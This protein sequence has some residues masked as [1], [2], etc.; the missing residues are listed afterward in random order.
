MAQ[1]EHPNLLEKVS[2]D[3]TATIQRQRIEEELEQTALLPAQQAA[4]K[5][6]PTVKERPKEEMFDRE[7]VHMPDSEDD[8]S[9]WRNFICLSHACHY[10]KLY[11]IPPGHEREQ[12][13]RMEVT[14]LREYRLLYR[15]KVHKLRTTVNRWSVLRK[16]I[17]NDKLRQ[18]LSQNWGRVNKSLS[19]VEV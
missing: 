2:I 4:E 1:T 11:S 8:N 19:D 9:L 15:A 5:Y 16:T 12:M 17:K 14:S 7:E 6:N 13:H 18:R 3:P 10:C